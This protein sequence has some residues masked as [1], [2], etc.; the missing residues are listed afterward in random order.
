MYHIIVLVDN[1]QALA[2]LT[3]RTNDLFKISV[4]IV[5][6]VVNGH[7]I[8]REELFDLRNVAGSRINDRLPFSKCFRSVLHSD[9]LRRTDQIFI[10]IVV[11]RYCCVQVVVRS[12][13][14]VVYVI[15]DA[16][17]DIV[18]ILCARLF[19]RIGLSFVKP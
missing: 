10:R 2:F 4:L 9:V 18:F 19:T 15:G 7:L 6:H 11:I 3:L 13:I 12:I 16:S 14:A 17:I 1:A 8:L 5:L